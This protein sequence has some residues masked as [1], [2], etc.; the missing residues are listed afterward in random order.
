MKIE[1][2]CMLINKNKAS[3][4]NINSSAPNVILSFNVAHN[5]ELN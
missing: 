1:E 5:H 3:R 4:H 2:N